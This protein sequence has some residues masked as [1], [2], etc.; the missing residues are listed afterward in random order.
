MTNICSGSS[1]DCIIREEDCCEVSAACY[2]C[3]SLVDTEYQYDPYFAQ[4]DV[5]DS[6]HWQCPDCI[7]S[8]S[9]NV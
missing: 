3:G 4:V 1:N 2:K 6:L 5:D 8:S 9:Q 7:D